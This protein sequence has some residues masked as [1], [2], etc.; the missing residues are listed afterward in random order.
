MHPFSLV[1]AG[2]RQNPRHAGAER[3]DQ[4]PGSAAQI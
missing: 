1:Q 3:R 2:K 4:R